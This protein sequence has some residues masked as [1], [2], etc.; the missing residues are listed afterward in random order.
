MKMLRIKKLLK[1]QL[2]LK[3]ISILSFLSIII[4]LLFCFVI[5]NPE[6][7]NLWENNPQI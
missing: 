2:M 1:I 6:D 7:S 3:L 5:T 4:D